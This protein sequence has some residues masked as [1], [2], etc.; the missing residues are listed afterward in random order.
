MGVSQFKTGYVERNIAKKKGGMLA[1]LLAGS[2]LTLLT[3]VFI[4]LVFPIIGLFE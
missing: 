4:K 3:V 2:V 1:F